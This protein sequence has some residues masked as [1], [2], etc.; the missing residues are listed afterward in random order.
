M[1]GALQAE[2]VLW[3]SDKGKKVITSLTYSSFKQKEFF[4]SHLSPCVMSSNPAATST[5]SPSPDE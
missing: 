3:A 2:E 1:G 5:P 4:F